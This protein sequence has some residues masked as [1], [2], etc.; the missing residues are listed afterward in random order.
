M[1]FHACNNYD[2]SDLGF[3]L[4]GGLLVK[5]LFSLV[6]MDIA[7]TKSLFYTILVIRPNYFYRVLYMHQ[8]CHLLTCRHD[9]SRA[10]RHVAEPQC[11]VCAP[12]LC[13]KDFCTELAMI[14]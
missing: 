4:G 11:I 10:L 9:Q 12:P 5:I 14:S 1:R 2:I 6:A 13:V 7:F 3:Q 8:D